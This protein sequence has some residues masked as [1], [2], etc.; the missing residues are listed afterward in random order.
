MYQNALSNLN[1]TIEDILAERDRVVIRWKICGKHTGEYMGIAATGQDVMVTGIAIR[2]F[3][4][5]KIIE[6]WVEMDRLGL[7]QQL[8]AGPISALTEK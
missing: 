2:R 5:G 3:E 6:E 4:D 8:K 1:F 7:M